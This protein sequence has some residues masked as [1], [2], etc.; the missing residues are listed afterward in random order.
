MDPYYINNPS[1]MRPGE[2]Y[3]QW[4]ARYGN[5]ANAGSSG[6]PGSQNTQSTPNYITSSLFQQQ[7]ASQNYLSGG[8]QSY[9]P[10]PTTPTDYS[11]LLSPEEQK[12]QS[13][14]D[15]LISLNEQAIGE[16][17]YRTEQENLG[18]IE[19]MRKTQ[20]DLEAQLK[21]LINESK[22]IP[23][24]IQNEFAGRGATA[25]GVAPI[26]TGRLR[27][28]AIK[29]LNVSSLLEASRGNLSNALDLVDRAVAQKYDPIK[30]KIAVASANLELILK[31]PAY[32]NAQ[33][34]RAQEQLDIQAKKD[35]DIKREEEAYK[36]VQAMA[37]A[38]VSN[39]PGNSAASLAAQQ[40]LKLDTSSPDYLMQAFNIIGQ[41]QSNPI[42]VQKSLLDL[43]YK[44]AQTSEM[45][46]KAAKAI[47]DLKASPGGSQLY[48]GLSS[49]TSTAVRSQVGKFAGEPM[50]QNFA[51][52]QEG[53]NFASN[54]SDTTTNPA[55]DQALIYALAKVL[56]PGSV[57]REG[58]YATAQKYSQSWASAFGKGVSQAILGTGFLSEQ[59][60]K[61]IKKTIEERY[62]ASKTSYDNLY[63]KYSKGI[64][65][66][67]GR[68]NGADFLID[69]ATPTSFGLAEQVR[70]M[71]YDYEAMKL[72]G[73]SDEEIKQSLGL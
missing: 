21:G 69:Y 49:Q 27:E 48:S 51:T 16:S 3:E 37:A 29:S 66:L 64:N 11:Y 32:T 39:N 68:T 5:Q 54:L 58:E 8:F 26:E 59:A 52:I 9:N 60:R 20:K 19:E 57:V 33:K 30:E 13:Y 50:V 63:S 23:L 10:T 70:G 45:K 53:Y 44:K 1:A 40:V 55:D 14:Y 62:K 34:K 65:I 42:E 15:K 17:A 7:Q 47:E 28:N 35:R 18:G 56:D 38:A 71:G 72:A 43:E 2:T 12:A 36:T 46:A 22:A 61:N 31:S 25:G 4:Q 73:H 24:Q 67:T 6:S 41:Y